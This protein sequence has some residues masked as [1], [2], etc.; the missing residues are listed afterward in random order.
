MVQTYPENP[1]FAAPS[2]EKVWNLLT[3]QLLDENFVVAGQRVIDH[4]NDHEID[5]VVD[6]EGAGI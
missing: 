6:I 2:E 4:D 1:R 5:F 3:E